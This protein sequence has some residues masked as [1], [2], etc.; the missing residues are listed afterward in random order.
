MK[1]LQNSI[2]LGVAALILA[3]GGSSLSAAP[4][5]YKFG[6]LPDTQWVDPDDGLSPTAIPASI[7]QQIDQAFIAQHVKLVIGVGDLTDHSSTPALEARALYA[8]S[9]YNAGIAF[10][11]LRGNHEIGDGNDSATDLATYFP[12]IVNG[13]VNNT[14]PINTSSIPA[15]VTAWGSNSYDS[16]TTI[17][18]AAFNNNPP[19]ANTGSAFTVGSNFQ[20]S[21]ATNVS[22]ANGTLADGGASYSFDFGNSRFVLLDQ[23]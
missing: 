19:G 9:L 6:V 12:Q 13:G 23:F 16:S 18:Q 7:V 15:I 17:T 4:T 21:T 1:N 8:Q 3:S 11:P 2:Y 10:Y 22:K 5:V 14:T 20:Y